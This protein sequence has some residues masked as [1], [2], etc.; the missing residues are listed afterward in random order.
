M[1]RSFTSFNRSVKDDGTDSNNAT[2]LMLDRTFAKETQG[3][4]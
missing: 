3:E 4:R 2:T 1:A